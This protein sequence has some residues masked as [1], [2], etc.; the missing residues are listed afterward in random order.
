MRKILTKRQIV[1]LQHQIFDPLCWWAPFYVRMNLCCSKI[2]RQ[3]DCWDSKV[4]PELVK[5]WTLAVQ[6]LAQIETVA[7]P[8]CRVPFI[9]SKD[10]YFE[11]H[12]FADS[13]KEVAAAAVYLRTV[14][15]DEC[16]LNLVA[17]KTSLLSQSEVARNSMPRKEIIAMDLGTRLLRECLDSTT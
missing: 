5:E 13:S 12:V 8:R 10:E 11:Y 2:V 7:F 3:V 9:S 15:G 14:S 6:D 1:S 17:A 4:P 16:S